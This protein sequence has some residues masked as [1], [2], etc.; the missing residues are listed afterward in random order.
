MEQT[1]S[2]YAFQ[3]VIDRIKSSQWIAD[4]KI[5]SEN[6][7]SSKLNVS[8][9]AVRQAYD[10]LDALGLIVKKRGSGTYISNLGEERQTVSACPVLSM[11]NDDVI[12][13]LKFR[14][15]FEHGNVQIFTEIC[16][17]EDV[18][19]LRVLVDIMDNA[20]DAYEYAKADFF[21]S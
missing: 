17:D 12:G 1:P 8:R 20:K 9:V 2:D 4:E 7:L 3:Y 5:L 13:L 19:K 16:T 11:D 6:E 21:V 10:K 18:D 15:F 14:K